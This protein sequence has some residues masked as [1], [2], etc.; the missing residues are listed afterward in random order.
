MREHAGFEEFYQAHYGR[1][2]ALITA[3][4]GDRAEAEDV[5]QDAFARALARWGRLSG[6]DLPEAWVRRVALRIAVDSGRR[7]RRATMVRARLSAQRPRRRRPLGYAPPRSPPCQ[8]L[9]H[10]L[11]NS[12][13]SSACAA[14]RAIL[15]PSRPAIMTTRRRG[16]SWWMPWPAMPARCCPSRTAASWSGRWRRRRNCWPTRVSGQDL[17]QDA[18]GTFTIARK[19]A[20]SRVISTVDPDARHGTRPLPAA[21]TG[22]RAVSR[23]TPIRRS[24][25]RCGHARQQRRR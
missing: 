19:V 23:S 15:S 9:E 24:S 11:G 12:S 18:G 21:L 4:I 2:V 25:P 22:T 8:S 20:A 5:V 6:Y 13:D 14:R 16:R 17:E 3:V 1:M 7:V 10:V